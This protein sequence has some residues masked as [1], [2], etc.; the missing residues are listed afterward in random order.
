V[1][2]MRRDAEGKR[3]QIFGVLL[4]MLTVLLAIC[5]VSFSSWDPSFNTQSYRTTYEN[6]AGRWGAAVSDGLFQALGLSAFL[7]LPPLA[8]V[9][10]KLIRGRASGAPLMRLLGFG[11][12]VGAVS[13]ALQIV[14]PG[15]PWW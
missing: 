7:L 15:P 2:E 9:G 5:L 14:R 1:T 11:L 10:W 6:R 3:H 13:A 4:L 12:L 8:I